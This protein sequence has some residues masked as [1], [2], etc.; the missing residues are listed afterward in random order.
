MKRFFFF[1]DEDEPESKINRTEDSSASG[2]EQSTKKT[3]AV[4]ELN[5]LTEF[6]DKSQSPPCTQEQGGDRSYHVLF[7][8]RDLD[9]ISTAL[10]QKIV[11]IVLV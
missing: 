9:G 11:F 1:S 4:S 7:F 3:G 6:R 2:D 10:R 5:N 8:L